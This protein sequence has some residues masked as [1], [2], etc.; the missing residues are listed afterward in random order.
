MI[1]S[2]ADS[3]AAK[4]KIRPVKWLELERKGER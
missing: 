3:V 2:G 1:D 4:F